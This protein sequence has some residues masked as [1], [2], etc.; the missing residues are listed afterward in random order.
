MEIHD[1][2]DRCTKTVGVRPTGAPTCSRFCGGSFH[3]GEQVFSRIQPSSLYLINRSPA[4]RFARMIDRRSPSSRRERD[5]IALP[6]NRALDSEYHIE[7]MGILR[8][9]GL[10]RALLHTWHFSR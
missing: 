8:R 2:K 7:N 3:C 6:M 1:G 5:K 9:L 4:V 10:L